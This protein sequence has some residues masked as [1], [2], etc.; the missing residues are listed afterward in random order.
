M[1][2][3]WSISAALTSSAEEDWLGSVSRS[4]S[5]DVCTENFVVPVNRGSFLGGHRRLLHL[6][7]LFPRIELLRPL[8]EVLLDL[9]DFRLPGVQFRVMPGKL[10]LGLGLLSVPRKSLLFPGFPTRVEVR[11]GACRLPAR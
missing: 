3:C 1:P 8:V 5:L 11:V 7:L 2:N 4:Q 6:P 10:L 9:S